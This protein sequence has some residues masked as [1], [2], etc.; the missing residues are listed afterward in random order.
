MRRST[1]RILTTHTGSLPRPPGLR[2]MLA[3]MSAGE[4]PEPNAFA[5]E[6]RD[7]VAQIVADQVEAGV[8]VVND[9]EASKVMYATYVT[10]RLS[11]FGDRGRAIGLGDVRDYPEWAH[12]A[13]FDDVG[14]MLAL[15]ACV[16]DVVYVD[17]GPLDADIEN[18]RAAADA[19]SPDDVF[20][21]AASPGVISLFLENQHYATRE[22]YLAAL[23]DAMKTEYDAIHAA[24]FVLQI[25]CPDL[26]M[27]RHIEFPDASLE[28]WRR[29]ITTNVEALNQ[30]TADI[31]PEDMRIH[32]C[33]GNYEGP[34]HLD[35]PL[36]DILDIVLRA[37]PAGIS[38]EAA[39][40]RHEHE[41]RVFEDVALPEGKVLI[42]G[43]IDSTTNYIEHPEL[44][45]E[46][47]LHFAGC[48]GRENVMAG[49]DCGFATMASMMP[50]NPNVTYA[51]LAAMAE[52]A[53]L[54]SD[55]LWSGRPAHRKVALASS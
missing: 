1:D 18:L 43:V 47:I 32:L 12:E 42:P 21:S 25:D 29:A 24:G 51:K 31:P 33:W 38:F 16:G 44:I 36:G 2:E 15:P 26:A 6:V 22:D 53:R 54:A 14:A 35:V 8:D 40:P 20:L 17:R 7:A 39:N 37:R 46:R 48:V 41:W 23:A 55:E 3:G 4:R 19:S 10:E 49:S 30:A 34:H 5:R 50:V 13:G 27:G 45:A 28:D 52:G 11:G 9:G